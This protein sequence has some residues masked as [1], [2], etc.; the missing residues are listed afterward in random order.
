M[1]ETEEYGNQTEQGVGYC[2]RCGAEARSTQE[3]HDHCKEAHGNQPTQFL[4]TLD[5]D[6]V[7]SDAIA[8]MDDL[9]ENWGDKNEREKQAKIVVISEILDGYDSVKGLQEGTDG[10]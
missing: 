2:A 8:E 1:S 6:Q 9:I 4:E 5:P 10:C 3:A 7:V